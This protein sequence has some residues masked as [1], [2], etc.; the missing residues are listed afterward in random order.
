[1]LMT[2]EDLIRAASEWRKQRITQFDTLT[3]MGYSYDMMNDEFRKGTL[4]VPAWPPA[5]PE[6]PAKK[7][8]KK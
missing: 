6:P 5:R 8:K 1:M 4:I 2:P 3:A 7:G